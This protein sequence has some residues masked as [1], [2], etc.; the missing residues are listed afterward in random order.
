MKNSTFEEEC[1]RID[2]MP[3]ILKEEVEKTL[4]EMD[5]FYSFCRMWG[6]SVAQEFG[7]CKLTAKWKGK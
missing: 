4:K 7:K 2:K 6:N 3:C 1:E 5:D